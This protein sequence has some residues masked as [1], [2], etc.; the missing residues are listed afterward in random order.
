VSAITAM[1]R[2]R[3]PVMPIHSKTT[4]TKSST[5][6]SCSLRGPSGSYGAGACDTVD[7]VK[8]VAVTFLVAVSVASAWLARR[9][10]RTG[11]VAGAQVPRGG[12][13]WLVV[14]VWAAVAAYAIVILV[15][16]I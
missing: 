14:L 4:A 16:I 5:G 10:H 1:P 15:R 9:T 11:I 2:R 7:A 3:L 6:S 12:Q 13:R 8:A